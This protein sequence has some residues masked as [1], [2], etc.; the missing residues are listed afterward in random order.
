MSTDIEQVIQQDDDLYD[1]SNGEEVQRTE[2]RPT[3][4]R[5]S[6]IVE[7]QTAAPAPTTPPEAAQEP[8]LVDDEHLPI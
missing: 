2:A 3:S 6:K 4:S 5:L 8:E 1:L 7:E